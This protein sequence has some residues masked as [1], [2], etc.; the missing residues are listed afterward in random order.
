MAAL[1]HWEIIRL[2]RLYEQRFHETCPLQDQA[3]AAL[4]A[5]YRGPGYTD[6]T[7]L[8]RLRD[9]VLDCVLA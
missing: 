9:S 4:R 6:A 8:R 2:R 7:I 5:D 3:I 1:E